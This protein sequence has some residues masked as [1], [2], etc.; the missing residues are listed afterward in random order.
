MRLSRIAIAA[1]FFA[2]GA[3]ILIPM[4]TNSSSPSASGSPTPSTS[5]IPPKTTSPTQ[6]RTPSP[7][8]SRRTTTPPP[9]VTPLA[10]L[11]VRIARVRCPG[12]SVQV[13]VAN[14]GGRTED[15]AITTDGS[16]AVADRIPAG[17]SRRSTV[18]VKEN[19]TTSI[20]VTWHN[21]PVENADRKADC[22]SGKNKALPSTGPD[23]GLIYA[24]IATGVAA[25]LTGVIIFWYGRLWP[26]RRSKMFD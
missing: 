22:A 2:V 21:V 3:L 17:K 13:T 1:I 16:I 7:S 15:Y 19:R 24:R 20:A 23:S 10:P 4:L 18:N 11:K 9:S 25:M 26:R 5:T 6:T 12:R 14:D 8:P